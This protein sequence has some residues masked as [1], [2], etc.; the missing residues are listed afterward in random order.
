MGNDEDGQVLYSTDSRREAVR[1]VGAK[2]WEGSSFDYSIGNQTQSNC[3]C[4]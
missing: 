3:R 4:M 1:V 2:R